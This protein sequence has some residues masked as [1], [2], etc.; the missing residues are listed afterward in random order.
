MFALRYNVVHTSKSLPYYSREEQRRGLADL[1][2]LQLVMKTVS[3]IGNL[4]VVSLKC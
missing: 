3:R 4:S 2:R 1:R